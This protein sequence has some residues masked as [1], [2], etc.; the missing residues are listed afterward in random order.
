MCVTGPWRDEVM[1]LDLVLQMYLQCYIKSEVLRTFEKKI[2][3]Q[4]DNI[5]VAPMYTWLF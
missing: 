4:V 5:S 1:N 2:Y 3:V